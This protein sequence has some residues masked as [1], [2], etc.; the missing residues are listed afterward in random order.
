MRFTVNKPDL[1]VSQGQLCVVRELPNSDASS[2]LVNVI[3]A[4]VRSMSLSVQ[5][6]WPEVSIRRESGLIHSLSNT[7]CCRREQ[8]PLKLFVASTIHKCMGD[9][10]PLVATQLSIT[11]PKYR[12]WLRSQLYVLISRVRLLKDIIFVGNESD[13]LN[14]IR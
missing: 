13:N 7:L 6:D 11:D 10:L 5:D 12:I 4:G 2:I 8:F 9:T 14:A 3:P 1:N